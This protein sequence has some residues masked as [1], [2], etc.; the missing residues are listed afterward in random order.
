MKK[1]SL[2]QLKRVVVTDPIGTAY[3]MRKLVEENIQL[4]TALK[5]YSTPFIDVARTCTKCKTITLIQT[6][7]DGKRA[8][9]ALRKRP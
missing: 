5:F 9:S 8:R 1:P 7:D 3:E 6:G 2:S 4:R